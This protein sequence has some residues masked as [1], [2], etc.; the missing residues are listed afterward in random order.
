MLSWP[1][2][3]EARRSVNLEEEEEEYVL[4]KDKIMV[5][6]LKKKKAGSCFNRI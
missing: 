5:H 4:E 1:D 2:G 6:R 3:K